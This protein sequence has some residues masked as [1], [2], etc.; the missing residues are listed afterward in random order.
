MEVHTPSP[1]QAIYVQCTMDLDSD[2]LCN[3]VP[4]IDFKNVK[5]TR[6]GVLHL[7]KLQAKTLHLYQ[8]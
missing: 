6:G 7:V 1:L 4:F 2:V 3:F 8:K 5:N